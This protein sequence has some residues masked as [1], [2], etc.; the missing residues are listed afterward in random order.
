VGELCSCHFVGALDCTLDVQEVRLA[1]SLRAPPCGWTLLAAL[2][3]FSPT[4]SG[5]MARVVSAV[6]ELNMLDLE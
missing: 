5:A 4:A 1:C 3:S 6:E 2:G